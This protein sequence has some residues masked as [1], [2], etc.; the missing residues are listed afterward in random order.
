MAL[1]DT[2]Y[3]INYTYKFTEIQKNIILIII[4]II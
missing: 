3:T 4:I 1:A 2:D